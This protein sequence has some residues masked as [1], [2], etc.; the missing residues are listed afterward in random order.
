LGSDQSYGSAG[1]FDLGL[2]AVDF[3]IQSYMRR[4]LQVFISSPGDVGVA[5]RLA[6]ET[7]DSLSQEYAGYFELDPY[8]WEHEAMV[9]SKHFQEI[10]QSPAECDIVILIIWSRLGTA[11]PPKFTGLDGRSPVTGTEWE[12]ETALVAATASGT[13]DILVFRDVSDTPIATLHRPA[14]DRALA[15]LDALDDFWSKH[16]A[17][18]SHFSAAFTQYRTSQ[19]F[20]ESLTAQLKRLLDRRIKRDLL[21]SSET[22]RI[23]VGPPHRGLEPY[24]FEHAQIFFGRDVEIRKSIEWLREGAA[25]GRAFLLICGASGSG[26]SSLVRAGILPRLMKPRRISGLAFVRRVA[27]RP[28]EAR[29]GGDVVLAFVRRLVVASGR[30]DWGLPELRGPDQTAEELAKLHNEHADVL[31]VLIRT[32]LSRL[33][34]KL[35]SQ[36]RLL[37]YEKAALIVVVDQLE[38]LF[39]VENI[40]ANQRRS[41]VRLL[42]RLANQGVVWIVA[43]MRADFWSRVLEISTLVE[44]VEAKGRLDLPAPTISALS[45]MIR[46]PVAL[47]GLAFDEHQ[48]GTISLDAAILDDAR[49]EPGALPLVSFA[50]SAVYAKDVVAD[51]GRVLTYA[52]YKD[53]GGLQG[54]IARKAEEIFSVQPQLVRDSFSL[55]LTSLVTVRDVAGTTAIARAAP[56]DEFAAGTPVRTLVE[57]FLSTDAR[58]LVADTA[59]G[60]GPV[61]RLAHEALLTHWPRAVEQI[62]V[63]RS[64]LVLRLHL[65][66]A[67]AALR[68]YSVANTPVLPVELTGPGMELLSRR[69]GFFSRELEAIVRSS[70]DAWRE[71]VHVYADFTA[72]MDAELGS[73]RRVA[74]RLSGK[75]LQFE[76]RTPA[77]EIVPL[78]SMENY[79]AGTEAVI[80]VDK[81]E[82]TKALLSCDLAIFV[83]GDYNR[84]MRTEE[85]DRIDIDML[86][87]CNLMLKFGRP[88]VVI[89]KVS[90]DLRWAPA[91]DRFLKQWP[92]ENRERLQIV[93]NF[94]SLPEF[95]HLLYDV[96]LSAVE[97][98]V[99]SEP[100]NLN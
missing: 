14:R 99:V 38:E 6:A 96:L 12:F 11:L 95:N 60:V 63:D 84:Q 16:F 76:I 50:L 69:P 28:S 29:E 65:E 20:V 75:N 66:S 98:P 44:L 36:E 31:S 100:A 42:E 67:V 58:L 91:W 43:T 45:D 72:D 8:L 94:N 71:L 81:D 56:L 2:L 46:R 33:T 62:E 40:D 1:I 18:E 83:I 15:Q 41:F 39:T 68:Q 4:K 53:L 35:R 48:E 61:V 79:E 22:G 30:D 57:A 86:R 85:Y 89:L 26:K 54:A 10:I 9:A 87:V 64:D 90:P 49:V 80:T 93:Q 3:V 13:P 97:R 70:N 37:P 32:V 88:R 34:N 52:T 59:A 23:W 77:T 27:F 25:R 17:K 19:E 7:V 24:E 55:M 92:P 5:R 82:K 73:L 51:G 78:A 21:P 74:A 47:T